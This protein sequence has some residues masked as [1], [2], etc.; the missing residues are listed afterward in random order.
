MAYWRIDSNIP[1]EEDTMYAIA[2]DADHAYQ[3]FC[4]DI[5]HIPRKY[6]NITE[7]SESDIPEGEDPLPI[8]F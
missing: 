3:I 2:N 1:D 8:P 6:L 5:G 7:C 4:K